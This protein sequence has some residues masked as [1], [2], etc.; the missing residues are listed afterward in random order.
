MARIGGD[1]GSYGGLITPFLHEVGGKYALLYVINS[2]DFN[3]DAVIKKVCDHPESKMLFE[4]TKNKTNWPT[5]NFL[6]LSK[7]ID[8]IDREN[9]LTL[10][11]P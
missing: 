6:P 11:T 8:F 1:I 7:A 9:F 4:M 10:T 5:P 3:L 2:G